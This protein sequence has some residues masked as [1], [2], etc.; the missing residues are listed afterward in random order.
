MQGHLTIQPQRKTLLN[1]KEATRTHLVIVFLPSP[2]AG[3][4]RGPPWRRWGDKARWDYRNNTSSSVWSWWWRW[5]PGRAPDNTR[6]SPHFSWQEHLV[7]SGQCEDVRIWR[8]EDV[9]MWGCED[10]RMWRCEDVR[11][12]LTNHFPF[13]V[14]NE[15][16]DIPAVL[17]V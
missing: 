16:A 15:G 1:N 7:R 9:R 6:R 8:C 12:C 17:G 3:W 2:A 10:V 11:H 4:S 14:L 13:P 5:C